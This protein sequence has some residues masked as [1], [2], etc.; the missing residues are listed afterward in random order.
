MALPSF[1]ISLRLLIMTAAALIMGVCVSAYFVYFRLR[2]HELTAVSE[3]LESTVSAAAA[4]LDASVVSRVAATLGTEPVDEEAVRQLNQQVAQLSASDALQPFTPLIRVLGVVHEPEDG[5]VVLAE[6]E[7]LAR[8]GYAEG[9]E[10]VPMALYLAMAMNGTPN[11]TGFDVGGVPDDPLS[12]ERLTAIFGNAFLNSWNRDY[13]IQ[14]A[15][16]IRNAENE[17]VGLLQMEGTTAAAPYNFWNLGGGI[18]LAGLCGVAPAF[19]VV[20]WVGRDWAKRL[21]KLT[22]EMA[23]VGQGR[24]DLRLNLGSGGG[25]FVKLERSFNQMTSGLEQ[26]YNRVRVSYQEMQVAKK[27]AED[28][29]QAKSDFL[30]NISHEIRTPMNGIIGT[31]H[32][33]LETKLTDEQ[34]ELVYIMRSSGESLV[35]LINDVLDFSKIESAK[36]EIENAPVNLPQLIEDTIE[37][38]VYTATEKNIELIYFIDK[39]V[40]DV[41]FGDYERIKQILVNLIGNALKFTEAGEIVVRVLSGSRNVDRGE[42]PVVKFSVQDTGIGISPENKERIF[43]AFTQADASTTRQYGGTGLGLAISRQLCRLMGGDLMVES[44]QGRGSNFFFELS[45]RE[46]PQQGAKKP[47]ENPELL[48]PLNGRRVVVVCRNESLGSLISHYCQIWSAAV[49]VVPSI[50]SGFIAQ[51]TGWAPDVVLIDP[52]SQDR[53]MV[54]L[55][56]RTMEQHGLSWIGLLAVG[57]EKPEELRDNQAAPIRFTYK[58]LS[59]LKLATSLAEIVLRRSGLTDEARLNSI[60]QTEAPSNRLFAEDFPAR[61]LLVEDVLTNQ[62]I[63]AMI[64]KKLGYKSVQ[65]AQNGQE[66]VEIVNSGEIDVVFMDLQMPVM[67][68]IEATKR[69]RSNFHLPRQ[70]LIIAMTGHALAGVRESCLEAGMDDYMTKPI[71]VVR[72]K[73][74]ISDNFGKLAMG[75]SARVDAAR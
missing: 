4:S 23:Q 50:E 10:L 49:H 41:I 13:S 9:L 19:L 72:V 2:E 26:T 8:P 27:Q 46:V 15:A 65:I 47:A 28:A 57:E 7:I 37:L 33:L 1:S 45:F 38:F 34:K 31:T 51:L 35:H 32:L 52:R 55:L 60:L 40:P 42:L 18:F 63:A 74:T 58:P 24:Y 25:E 30:A 56:C 69:I 6:P 71:S 67:G 3:R 68:G 66:G 61:V 11:S 48:A 62:R 75:R 22:T 73:E 54:G 36:M 64:L 44:E 59:E 29:Q 53:E 17:V 5:I 12:L 43:E 21:L 14:L 20:F 70:P 16:P 39:A